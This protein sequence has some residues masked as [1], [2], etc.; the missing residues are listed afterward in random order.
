MAIAYDDYIYRLS[1]VA[2]QSVFSIDLPKDLEWK[3]ELNW[4]TVDQ[5]VEYSLTGALLIQEGVKQKGRPITFTGKDNMAWI[6]REQGLTLL[7]MR[8]TQGLVMTLKFLNKNAPASVLFSFNVMFRHSEG[9][10]DLSNIKD[11]D[12]YESDAWYIV[13]AIRLM[14]TTA[15]GE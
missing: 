10:V 4:G 14:E 8:N 1:T 12:Q 3:D 2:P 5:I 11:F 13:N 6:T 15:Y 9:A 7:A